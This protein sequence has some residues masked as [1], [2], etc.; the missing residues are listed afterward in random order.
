MYW[1]LPVS[2]FH[3]G[4][5]HVYYWCA[6]PGWICR[7]ITAAATVTSSVVSRWTTA[8]PS[9][10]N[11]LSTQTQTRAD[12]ATARHSTSLQTTTASTGISFIP[13]AVQSA[14]TR[15]REQSR[16]TTLVLPGSLFSRY[17]TPLPLITCTGVNVHLYSPK[18]VEKKN[19][20]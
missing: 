5:S 12:H 3:E 6:L 20:D 10:P 19:N 9:V 13:N 8:W 4:V 16:S 14:T 11:F 17:I 15:S 1:S 18:T 2:L 7:G